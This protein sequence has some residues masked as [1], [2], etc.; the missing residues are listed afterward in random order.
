MNA[1]EHGNR[2]DPSLPVEV[3][4]RRTAEAVAVDVA[5][6]GRGAGTAAEAPDLDRKLA[7]LQ[8]PRGWGRF[9]VERLTD[10]VE[11]FLAGDRHVVRLT[12]TIGDEPSPEGGPS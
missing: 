10:R 4:V 12:M 2:G 11:E 1:I 6:F 8:P 9:L 7:G 5:D 3:T